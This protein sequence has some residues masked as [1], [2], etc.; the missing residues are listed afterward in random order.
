MISELGKAGRQWHAREA[1]LTC[2]NVARAGVSAT[3]T[4]LGGGALGLTE[5]GQPVTLIVG[6]RSV[7]SCGGAAVASEVS[8]LFADLS[9]AR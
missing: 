4:R 8:S 3:T 9:G 7:K 1:E 5:T 2:A 6:H